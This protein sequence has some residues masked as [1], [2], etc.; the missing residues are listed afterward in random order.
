MKSDSGRLFLGED[1]GR[2][3]SAP[4]L[5]E[6]WT[7]GPTLPFKGWSPH[8]GRHY[9]ACKTLMDRLQ[10]QTIRGPHTVTSTAEEIITLVLKPQLGHIS[11]ETT[12]IYLRWIQR[13][14]T[15]APMH[16]SYVEALENICQEE[17]DGAA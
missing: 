3:I 17:Q 14:F 12:Q 6:A 15:D 1:S 13:L 11:T 2:P 9:Y 10:R 7:S 8:G 5:Y 4:T 16:V